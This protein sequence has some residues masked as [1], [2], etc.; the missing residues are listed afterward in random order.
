MPFVSWY[1]YIHLNCNIDQQ[2]GMT[3]LHC[4][5]REGKTGVVKALVQAGS[6]VDE[7]DDV[8]MI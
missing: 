1:L 8:R 6:N 5:A 7:K 3:P 4:A 2:Q